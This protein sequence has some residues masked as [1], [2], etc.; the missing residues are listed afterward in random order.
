MSRQSTVTMEL[1]HRGLG[2]CFLQ[3]GINH[4]GDQELPPEGEP[5]PR[6]AEYREG[7]RWNSGYVVSLDPAVPEASLIFI[8]LFVFR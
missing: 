8:G 6:T 2:W 7:H 4:S 5:S 3:T 1:Y